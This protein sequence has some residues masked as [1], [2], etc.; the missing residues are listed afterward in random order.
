MIKVYFAHPME[1]LKIPEE[2]GQ[3]AYEARKLLGE[4]F[5]LLIPEEWQEEVDNH[6]DIQ[7]VDLG[8]LAEADVI[9]VDFYKM[10]LLR[11]DATVLGRGT[12]Q[13]VGFIKGL[14]L[15]R[16][17]KV[18]IVQVIR[19]HSSEAIH[20][21]DKEDENL[22]NFNS[23]EAACEYIKVQLKEFNKNAI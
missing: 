12:N 22:T 13:E 11:N 6:N 20:P 23:L 8:H 1:G 17:R 21:F 18:P 14:N 5:E 3:R 2:S 10:G 4:E 19:Q 16:K 7:S 9:L 15:T